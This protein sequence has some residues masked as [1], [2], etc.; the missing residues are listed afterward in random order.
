[1]ATTP[2][3]AGSVVGTV[4][5]MANGVGT[6]GGMPAYHVCMGTPDNVITGTTGSDICWDSVGRQFYM[7]DAGTPGGS[8]W[9][10]LA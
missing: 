10:V 6:S 8:E 5:G 1:M 9:T 2:L 7:N 4:D 3:S